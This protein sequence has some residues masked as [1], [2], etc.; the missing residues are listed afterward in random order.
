MIVEGNGP[1]IADKY[2]P[3]L[4]KLYFTTKQNGLG[5]GLATAKK[6]FDAQGIKVKVESE[7]KKGMQIFHPHPPINN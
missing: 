2:K 6:I 3:M 7:E 4:F 5:I 1:G